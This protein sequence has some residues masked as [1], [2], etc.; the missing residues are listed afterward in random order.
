[1]KLA[2]NGI[3]PPKQWIHDP[4][5]KFL[6]IYTVADHFKFN[7]LPVPNEWYYGFMKI[8]KRNPD[9]I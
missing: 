2:F 6:K 1:M 5:I 3:I 8:K 7:N 9:F 4:N